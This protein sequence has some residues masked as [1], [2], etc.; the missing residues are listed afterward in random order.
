M[1]TGSASATRQTLTFAEIDN[2]LLTCAPE[3]LAANGRKVVAQEDGS[4]DTAKPTVMAFI[5]LAAE[6]LRCSLLLLSSRETVETLVPDAVRQARVP[7]ELAIR[8]VLGELANMMAGRVKN[9][10]LAHGVQAFSSTPT[11]VFGDEV[12]IPAPRSG[13][14]AWHRFAGGGVDLWVRLDTT[15]ES[16]FELAPADDS[17]AVHA[18]DGELVLF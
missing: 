11:T 5:G 2:Y 7:P 8:D 1:A 15:F 10:L 12:A 3:L 4:V 16:G 6:G 9:G 18:K 14:S 13:M 17:R